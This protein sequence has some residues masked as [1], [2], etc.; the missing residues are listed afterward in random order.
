MRFKCRIPEDG[1]VRERTRF[2]LFPKW[3]DGEIRW[4]EKATW[5]ESYLSN[6]T[7]SGWI[8]TIWINN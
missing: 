3:I 1:D 6:Y 5:Q 8:E 7:G 2:L 4:L